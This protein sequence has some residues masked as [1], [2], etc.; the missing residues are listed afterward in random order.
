MPSS[1]FS[2][3]L[4]LILYATVPGGSREAATPAPEVAPDVPLDAARRPTRT[5]RSVQPFT[6]LEGRTL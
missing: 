3:P 6:P 1:R 2:A 4:S 5:A